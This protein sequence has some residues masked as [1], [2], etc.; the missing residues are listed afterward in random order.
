MAKSGFERFSDFDACISLET[1]PRTGTSIR[2]DASAEALAQLAEDLGLAGVEHVHGELDVR[3][4]GRE[5]ALLEGRVQASLSQTCVVSFAPV[6]ST[7][8]EPVSLIYAP[9]AEPDAP[10][11]TPASEGH[12]IDDTEPLMDGLIPVGAALR[13]TIALAIDPYPHAPGVDVGTA[14]TPDNPEL[15][16]FAVL[17]QL[18]S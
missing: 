4:K 11:A 6:P 9:L 8:D 10:S 12:E 7:L 17:K 18:K 3:H 13:D 1:V 15:S 14:D 5:G 16:P 2:F